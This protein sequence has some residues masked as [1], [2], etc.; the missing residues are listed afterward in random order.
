MGTRGAVMRKLSANTHREEHAHPAGGQS[1]P[2]AAG[3]LH[4]T[5]AYSPPWRDCQVRELTGTSA[6]GSAP[7]SPRPRR[8]LVVSLTSHFSGPCSGLGF[9]PCKSEMGKWKKN[10]GEK[11]NTHGGGPGTGSERRTRPALFVG[12]A[13]GFLSRHP[14]ARGTLLRSLFWHVL[15]S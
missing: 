2:E 14:Q 1:L 5:E 13:D 3:L 15:E 8:S 11:K 7:C 4:L 6:L 10:R 12:P 9:P